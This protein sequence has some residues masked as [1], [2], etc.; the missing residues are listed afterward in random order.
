M[1]TERVIA[2]AAALLCAVGS[3]SCTKKNTDSK[4]EQE[5]TTAAVTE[6]QTTEALC[7]C[8]RPLTLSLSVDENGEP[9]LTDIPVDSGEE[10][11]A[12]TLSLRQ[13]I[14]R[15]SDEERRIIELRYFRSLTQSQTA[16]FLGTTQ[17]R[18]CRREKKILAILKERLS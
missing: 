2:A 8:R 16:R 17:V 3:Y 1:K 14:S 10:R 9:S 13:E 5:A 15:L 4:K 12:E 6:E 7:A 18:I 11:L